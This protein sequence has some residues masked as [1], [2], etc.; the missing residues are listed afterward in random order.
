MSEPSSLTGPDLEQGIDETA[1]VAGVPLLGHAHGE[2][3][4]LV[5]AEGEVFAVAATC[6]HY[7]G[8][9][10]EGLVVG[11]SVRCPWHHACFELKTGAVLG[12]P[13]F[14]PISCFHVEKAGVRLR[15]GARLPPAPAV[16]VGDSATNIVI[17]GAG[18]AGHYAAETLRANGFRGVIRLLG[19][20]PSVPYDRPNLSKDFLAGNAPE[21]WIPLRPRAYYEEKAIQLETGVDVARLDVSGRQVILA[22]GRRMDFDRLLLATGAE[23]VPLPVPGADAPHVHL[24][25]TLDDCRRLIAAA[26][27]ASRVALIGSGFIGLEAAAALRARGLDVA[28]ISPDT[29]PLARVV[30]P[31]VAA[32][33]RRLH[34]EHG[35]K[36]H[37]QESVVRIDGDAVVTASGQRVPADLVLVA[38]GVRPVTALASAAGLTVDNGV[39]VDELLETSA[40]GVFAAGDVARYPDPRSGKRIRV[41]HWAVAQQMAAVAAANMLGMHR[42][43]VD[44]P[45]FWSVHYDVTLSYVGHSETVTDLTIDGSIEGRDCRVQYQENGKIAAVLTIGRD[46]QSLEAGRA[47]ELRV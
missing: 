37:L 17:V 44:V 20:D 13:A 15:V 26:G 28:V 5:R 22:D 42:R 39:V 38:I 12:A 41:E 11:G 7:G 24:L 18:A 3:V 46:R 40:R 16:P 31:Q 10:A 36:F 34:E 45:F 32:F 2:P 21:E 19:R 23:P 47:L 25:R 35:V 33:L 6:S 8:P 1:V 29:A 30:G 14:N 27:K 43:F 4:M 9:L